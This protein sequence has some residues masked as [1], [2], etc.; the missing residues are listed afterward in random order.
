MAPKRGVAAAPEA[1]ARVSKKRAR[2]VAA[3][4]AS[5]PA[6]RYALV[7]GANPYLAFH[8]ESMAALP[9]DVGRIFDPALDDERR[10]ELDAAVCG[11]L[12]EELVARYAWAVPDERA[13]RIIK[14][15][16]PIIEIGAGSGYW[17]ACLRDRGV[18]VVCA[19]QHTGGGGRRA[20]A[21]WTEVLRA[22]PA[23]CKQHTARTLLLVYPDDFERSAESVA[24]RFG[25]P[26][27]RGPPGSE[28]G[29][30]LGP[31]AVLRTRS[32][33]APTACS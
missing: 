25:A 2:A 9:A 14:H 29:A 8:A 31:A 16:G 4:G 23:L 24:L 13:L 5:P 11:V 21:V 32:C 6:E 1:A 28:L 15:F 30:A 7:P 10:D 27:A 26:R 22:G 12:T 17:A 3:D 33:A 18:D 20:A 19:D